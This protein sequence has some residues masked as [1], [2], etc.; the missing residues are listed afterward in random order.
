MSKLLKRMWRSPR[1]ARVLFAV[2]APPLATIFFAPLWAVAFSI[3]ASLA[4]AVFIYAEI[5]SPK[6]V[7]QGNNSKSSKVGLVRPKGTTTELS[8]ATQS[9]ASTVPECP[10]TIDGDK[11]KASSDLNV[12]TTALS[13]RLAT[14]SARQKEWSEYAQKA[15]TSS[16]NAQSEIRSVIKLS[17]HSALA[18]ANCIRE[19]ERNHDA[20][21]HLSK[22][23]LESTSAQKSQQP[24][25]YDLAHRASDVLRRQNKT[26]EASAEYATRLIQKQK[27]AMLIA[28]RV[29]QLLDEADN[30]SKRAIVKSP[31]PG[32]TSENQE[33]AATD[34][35]SSKAQFPWTFVQ[36]HGNT[37]P[38]LRSDFASTLAALEQVTF[39]MQTNVDAIGDSSEKNSLEVR[40]V[41]GLI[42]L[43]LE[44]TRGALNAL[45]ELSKDTQ[46]HLQA[47]IVAMQYH[48]LMTQKL[49]AVDNLH[50]ESIVIRTRNMISGATK[51]PHTAMEP[52]PLERASKPVALHQSNEVD[53]F[54]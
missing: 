39:D 31:S 51:P 5:L 12:E 46:S 42:Q 19:I 7:Q 35:L 37:L 13:S 26:L 40:S 20:H 38:N 24:S 3:T 6:F 16:N 48:D 41:T 36:N 10:K 23:L 14:P 45:N 15:L 8:D 30:A 2:I 29:D 43:K 44:E 32:V 17:T 53:F 34:D 1:L 11:N 54:D 25:L 28:A 33:V 21:F 49:S 9:I 4:A 18:L 47:S 52:T 22:G 50:L 27:S